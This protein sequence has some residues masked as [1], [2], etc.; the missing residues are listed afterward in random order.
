MRLGHYPWNVYFGADTILH[1]C[2]HRKR[3]GMIIKNSD[4]FPRSVRLKT[5]TLV[6][7]PGEAV[8]ITSQ[9]VL[10]PILLDVLQAR[11]LSIVRP[12]SE[13]EEEAVYESLR[14]R[15]RRRR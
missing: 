10:D 1:Q 12:I 13:E 4:P 9:E 11:E 5:R 8:P 14:K 6:L 3:K 7:N 15:K 2:M